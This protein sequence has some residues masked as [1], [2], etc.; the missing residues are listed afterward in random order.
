MV[1]PFQ[2]E[3]TYQ[4]R[5]NIIQ[6]YPER[7]WGVAQFSELSYECWTQITGVSLRDPQGYLGGVTADTGLFI[8]S[9]KE[10]QTTAT[11]GDYI[12]ICDPIDFQSCSDVDPAYLNRLA[13]STFKDIPLWYGSNLYSYNETTRAWTDLLSADPVTFLED[14]SAGYGIGTPYRTSEILQSFSDVDTA[15]SA[16]KAIRGSINAYVRLYNDIMNASYTTQSGSYYAY[17]DESGEIGG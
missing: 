9:F 8:F 14:V 6:E 10:N 7:Y 16:A 1:S 15:T 17:S 12:R 11:G 4:Q 13:G 2:I 3:Y 5:R